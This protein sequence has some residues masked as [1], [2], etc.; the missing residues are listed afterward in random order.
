LLKAID[1]TGA[2]LNPGQQAAM[3]GFATLLGGGLA[4]LAG[5]NAQGGALAAQNEVLNNTDEHPEDAAK[6]GGVLS[7]LGGAF[8]DALKATSN[9]RG[10]VQSQ[11]DQFIGLMNANSGQTPPS[12]PNPLGQANDGNPPSTGA[13]PVTPPVPVCDPPVCTWSP[14]LPGTPSHIT[15]SSGN[16]G[17]DSGAGTGMLGENGPQFASKTIWKGDGQERIDVENPNPDSDRG[18][19]TTRTITATSICM[20]R[21]RTRSRVRRIQLTNC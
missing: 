16:S 6:N 19:S 5:A 15:I 8:V 3:A 1:P 13:S 7:T 14:A 10:W 18:K 2:D 20:I 9:A 17:D 12:D 21:I 11:V 4:G